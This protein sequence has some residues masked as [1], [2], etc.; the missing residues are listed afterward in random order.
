MIQIG[1]R[2]SIYG[3]DEHDWAK[4]QGIRIVCM[5]KFTARG[6][7]FVIAEARAIIRDA[8]TYVT[9]DI[10][11][12]DP[13]MARALAPPKLAGSPPRKHNRYRAS[14]R[15]STWRVRMWSKCHLRSISVA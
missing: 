10:D 9:F 7:E 6:D 15:G 4:A 14:L 11:S 8:P 5:E 2:G 12:I 3:P 13:S 1:I